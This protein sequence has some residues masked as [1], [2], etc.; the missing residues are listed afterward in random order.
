ML[1]IIIDDRQFLAGCQIGRLET[2]I[3]NDAR[4]SNGYPYFW[5]VD[6]GRGPVVAKN[7]KALRF[8]TP[9]GQVLFRKSVGPA[10][11]RDIRKTA[12]SQMESSAINA[13]IT[14]GGRD[15]RQWLAVFLTK[16]GYFYSQVLAD[17]TPRR[18]GKLASRYRSTTI[19]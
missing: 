1:E 14:A 6:L 18:T 16:M 2:D 13:S 4:S 5:P 8:V 19:A 11:P 12:I 3:F 15:I 9:G 10:A 7:A 17:A